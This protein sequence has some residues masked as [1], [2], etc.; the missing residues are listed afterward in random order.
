MK[1]AKRP[2]GRPAK[3]ATDPL[4]PQEEEFCLRVVSGEL[5]S[6]VAQDLWPQLVNPSDRGSYLINHDP[7]IQAYMR[8]LSEHSE[9][10]VRQLLEAM[11]FGFEDRLKLIVDVAKLGS[12]NPTASLGAC[13]HL[14]KLEGRSEEDYKR[15][16][17]TTLNFY[18]QAILQPRG[19][20]KDSL[21]L[22]DLCGRVLDDSA[23]AG[24]EACSVPLE[25]DADGPG[26]AQN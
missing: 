18:A 8:G 26:E 24:R 20:A 12:K 23:E 13:K 9:R 25:Q 5:R 19:S 17:N 15:A 10:R 6:K 1:Q 22:P 2:P 11:D 21:R 16:G 4:T 3:Q 7:R 14:D